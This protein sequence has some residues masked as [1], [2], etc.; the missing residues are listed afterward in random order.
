[1]IPR[2]SDNRHLGQFTQGAEAQYVSGFS[3]GGIAAIGN[4]SGLP[5]ARFPA[6]MF[7]RKPEQSA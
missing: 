3:L 1:M 4:L 5:I 6:G 2:L 7:A